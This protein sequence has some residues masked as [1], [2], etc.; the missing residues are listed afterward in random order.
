VLVD[1]P[2][3]SGKSQIT[4]RHGPTWAMATLGLSVA[5]VSYGSSTPLQPVVSYAPS[6]PP[7]C[8]RTS[9]APR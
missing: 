2:P 7:R 6:K 3:Q 1:A 9:R 8:G 4:S 5:I